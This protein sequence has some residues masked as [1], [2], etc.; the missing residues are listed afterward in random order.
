MTSPR[1][2]VVKSAD[3]VLDVLEALVHSGRG[4]THA[5][6]SVDLGIP[7]SSLTQLLGNLVER[8]YL[9]FKSGPNLYE[10]GPR[11]VQLVERQSQVMGL[12]RVAQRYCDRLAKETGESAS[13]SVQVNDMSERLCGTNSTQSLTFN[14]QVGQTAPAYAVSS[15]KVMLAYM[16]DAGLSQYLASVELQAFTKKTITRASELKKEL[17]HIR[18]DGLAW[19]LEEYTPGIIGLAVP[20]FDAQGKQVGSLNIAYPAARDSAIQRKRLAAVLRGA[21]ASMQAELAA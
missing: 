19:S 21:A 13:F 5:R 4:A 12:P 17:E 11:L 15:G 20:V 1:F 3:R 8:G 14:M 16:D 6:L 2:A 9:S 10:I 18:K 7:K